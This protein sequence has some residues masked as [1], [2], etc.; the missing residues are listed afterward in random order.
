MAHPTRFHLEKDFS[1]RGPRH[2][3]LLNDQRHAGFVKDGSYQSPTPSYAPPGV[4][5]KQTGETAA[6]PVGQLT[7]APAYDG[8]TTLRKTMAKV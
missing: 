6:S 8:T 7:E 4:P 1:R 2:F 5:V 3:P